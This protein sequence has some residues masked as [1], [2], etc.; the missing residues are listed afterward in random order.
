M[1]SIIPIITAPAVSPNVFERIRFTGTLSID[2]GAIQYGRA[3]SIGIYWSDHAPIQNFLNAGTIWASSTTG[4]ASALA[5][6][7]LFD[8]RNSGTMVRQSIAGNVSGISVGGLGDYLENT[9]RIFGLTQGGQAH[10]VVHYG[11]G[12]SIHN[13]G[14]GVIAAQSLGDSPAGVS[15]SIGVYMVN[16]GYVFNARGASILAEG[17][18][19]RAIHAGIGVSILNDGLIAARADS[20]DWPATAISMS[21]HPVY[22]AEVVNNGTIDAEVAISSSQLFYSPLGYG[23][24]RVEN[25]AEGIIRGAIELE[26]GYDIV[27]NRGTIVGDVSTGE[28]DDLFDTSAGNWLGFGDLG[29]GNDRLIGSKSDD[30]VN[31]SRGD[32]DMRGGLGNDLLIGGVGNDTISGD[33]G[34]DGL[35]GEHDEDL[36]LTLGG[37]VADGGDG[38]DIMIAGDLS[39][40]RLDGGAGIDTLA[41]AKGALKLDLSAA[42]LTD[43]LHSIEVIALETDQHLAIRPGDAS[44]LAGGTLR[45]VGNAASRIELIGAWE[46]QGAVQ[47][48]GAS[49]DRFGLGGDTVMIA[50]GIPVSIVQAPGAGFHG[51]APV[52]AGPAAPLIGSSERAMPTNAVMPTAGYLL[53][54]S[55]VIR[56]S[57]T[58]HSIDGSTVIIGQTMDTT[59]INHGTIEATGHT[60]IVFALFGNQWGTLV[61]DGLIRATGTGT[62]WATAYDPGSFGRLDNSGTIEAVADR[63]GTFGVVVSGGAAD[64]A[65]M[66]RN[67]G[68][69]SARSLAGPAVGAEISTMVGPNNGPSAINTGKIEAIGGTGTVAV[70]MLAGGVFRNEGTILADNSTTSEVHDA[71][72]LQLFN[73]GMLRSNGVDNRGTIIA[74]IAI[75]SDGGADQIVNS[76]RIEGNIRLN[77][78]DDSLIDGGIIIGAIDLGAG[79]DTYDGSVAGSAASVFGGTGADRL[80]GTAFDDVLV[81]GTGD[82]TIDGRAGRDVV[83]IGDALAD[84]TIAFDGSTCVVTTKTEGTDR[85]SNVEIIEFAGVATNVAALKAQFGDM[86]PPDLLEISP[87]LGGAAVQVDTSIILRFSE[88]VSRGAGTIRL[89]RSDGRIIETFDI[90]SSD[91]VHFSGTMLTIDPTYDLA[92][93]TRYRIEIDSGTIVDLS[94]NPYAGFVAYDF[95]TLAS[96]APEGGHARLISI[97]DMIAAIGG[98]ATI[99]GSID[100][101]DIHIVDQPGH[102]VFDSSFARGGDVVRLTGKAA[103]YLVKISGSGILFDDGDTSILIPIGIVG[104]SLSF[105]DGVRT[106]VFSNDEARVGAQ[107]VSDIFRTLDVPAERP[108]LPASNEA[109]GFGR[110]V[111]TPGGAATIGGDIEIFGTN[112]GKETLEVRSG[113]IRLDGSFARG[114]DVI[115]LDELSGDFDARLIG[116]IVEMRSADTALLV[117]VGT[118]GIT[119]RFI[120]GERTM[121][122]DAAIDAV[123]I[124]DQIVG[125]S[126]ISLVGPAHAS[127]AMSFA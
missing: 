100:R 67:S 99:F 58:W 17:G 57:E 101:Q 33:G 23:G 51:L 26:L 48:D 10:G 9:G 123:R 46:N 74:D 69:I 43:R 62:T 114:G 20:A 121:A 97:G 84:C 3:E 104:L 8:I 63:G 107:I 102:A 5:G 112:I 18:V 117:P 21:Y 34:N 50:T 118:V 103:D 59:L 12:V 25:G 115:I 55:M 65:V 125:T 76:G 81:G 49:F 72:G 60:N 70:Q 127:L 1:S 14:G 122:Y 87:A 98:N 111:I 30:V 116:S 64:P 37:D 16:G 91:R 119:L 31:G 47:S 29:W 19:A 38:D 32:D 86:V 113:D 105:D 7:Y 24:T 89:I 39:F 66:F 110:L 83:R 15:S 6:F 126:M 78:G 27:I 42:L 56:A 77:D 71:V 106:L 22:G 4:G 93:G 80:T 120:D 36:I 85:I 61:N 35:Y 41:F 82:D 54:G 40:A 53:S 94:D 75:R 2:A 108:S 95:T 88:N 28:G 109:T 79:N 92:A 90:A 52:A 73:Q 11:M 13:T 124:G 68:L 44:Q 96:P 45:I